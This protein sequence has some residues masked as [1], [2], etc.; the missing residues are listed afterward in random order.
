MTASSS[1][2]GRSL[3]GL[4]SRLLGVSERR[5]FH[6]VIGVR[7]A[8]QAHVSMGASREFSLSGLSFSL[9]VELPLDERVVI[10]FFVPG[11]R[12]RV[13]LEAE[14]VR[15]FMDPE[16]GAACYGARFVG[17]SAEERDMLKGFVWGES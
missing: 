14:I 13:A 16:D 17:L 1:I 8:G 2:A 12:Q 3:L 5:I 15:S 7:R 4:T 9:E 6:A 11:A 10:T